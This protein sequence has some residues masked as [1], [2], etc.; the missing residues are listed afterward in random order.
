[1]WSTRCAAEAA[2]PFWTVPNEATWARYNDL[3]RQ[4]YNQ[5]RPANDDAHRRIVFSE[6]ILFAY[7]EAR[8]PAFSASQAAESLAWPCSIRCFSA[9]SCCFAA[10]MRARAS[11]PAGAFASRPLRHDS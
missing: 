9:S 11:L 2:L 4:H 1:M 6:A 5:V 8:T 10:T 7:T 3:C